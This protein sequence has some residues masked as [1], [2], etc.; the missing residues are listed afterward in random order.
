[1]E[2]VIA[3]RAGGETKEQAKARLGGVAVST[4]GFYN[5]RSMALADF[6][7]LDGAILSGASTG[8]P[9]FAATSDGRMF[10]TEDYGIKGLSGVTAIALGQRLI[11]LQ[12]DGFSSAFMRETT[13]R[14]ALGMNGEYVF[15]VQGKSDLYRLAEFMRKKLPVRIAVNAD[16]GHVVRGKSPVHI[17]FRWRH[18]SA[19]LTQ[20]PALDQ[21]Q[22]MCLP[23]RASGIA[24]PEPEG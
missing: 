10:L 8:R 24:Q 9:L 14:M 1:M 19:G 2:A 7:Q 12:K 16:G 20:T 6:Y 21:L 22:L 23:S 4:A 17:V 11:P 15:I 3:Y 13:D 5:P 18:G